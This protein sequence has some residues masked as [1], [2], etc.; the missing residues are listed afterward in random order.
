MRREVM[1]GELRPGAVHWI[2][3][4]VVPTNDMIRWER[5]MEDILG[6]TVGH[7]GGLTTREYNRGG[8]IRTFYDVGRHE[9]GGFL[10]T[11]LLPEPTPLGTGLPRYG[12]FVRPEE[13]EG[14]LRRFDEAGVQHSDPMV[15]SDGGEE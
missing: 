6:A 3:H 2:D 1:T 4:F 14:H 13:M 10:Q 9:L 15:I 8:Y 7:R 5:F 11:D 12:F